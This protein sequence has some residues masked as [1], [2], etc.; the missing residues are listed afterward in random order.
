VV[1]LYAGEAD[2]AWDLYQELLGV[3]SFAESDEAVATE[4]LFELYRDEDE[5]GIKKHVKNAGEGGFGGSEE[6]CIVGGEERW[7]EGWEVLPGRVSEGE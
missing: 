6:G 3:D 7:G 4:R 2:K 1:W 5:A